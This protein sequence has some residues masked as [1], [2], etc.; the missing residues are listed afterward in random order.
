MSEFKTKFFLRNYIDYRPIIEQEIEKVA[1]ARILAK[2]LAKGSCLDAPYIPGMVSLGPDNGRYVKTNDLAPSPGK[3]YFVCEDGRYRKI[4][5][6][7]L[8]KFEPSISYMEIEKGPGYVYKINAPGWFYRC[9]VYRPGTQLESRGRTAIL[10]ASDPINLVSDGSYGRMLYMTGTNKTGSEAGATSDDSSNNMFPIHPGKNTYAYFVRDQNIN[11]PIREL[12]FVPAVVSMCYGIRPEDMVSIVGVGKSTVGIT[13]DITPGS[14]NCKLI[15]GNTAIEW[16]ENFRVMFG[17]KVADERQQ[18]I[19][20]LG[21][22]VTLTN[23]NDIQAYGSNSAPEGFLDFRNWRRQ[24]LSYLG[25][26]YDTSN[27]SSS[28]APLICN[29]KY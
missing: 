14:D 10:L 13:G 26:S 18:K 3:T 12:F 29:Y 17:R 16:L 19:K 8:S 23:Q 25:V 9:K 6:G 27:A 21:D 4:A 15:F 20:F 24:W 1:K 7:S 11:S 5:G 2:I 22:N 28:L